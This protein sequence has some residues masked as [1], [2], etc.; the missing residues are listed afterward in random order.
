MSKLSSPEMWTAKVQLASHVMCCK[1]FS[2]LTDI[3]YSLPEEL[4]ERLDS[5]RVM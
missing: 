1:R 4:N 3:F 2:L 5:P